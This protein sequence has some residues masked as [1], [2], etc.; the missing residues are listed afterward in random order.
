MW[1]S[2]AITWIN[3]TF[4]CFRCFFF[5]T[6]RPQSQKWSRKWT[7]PPQHIYTETWATGSGPAQHLVRAD[8]L[9]TIWKMHLSL[10]SLLVFFSTWAVFVSGPPERNS[11]GDT[12]L[13]YLCYLKVS[14]VQTRVELLPLRS[15]RPL[16]SGNYS[17]AVFP[18]DLWYSCPQYPHNTFVEFPKWMKS[19]F[20]QLFWKVKHWSVLS[21][22]GCIILLCKPNCETA[23][24]ENEK[25]NFVLVLQE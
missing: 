23:E 7:L 3:S 4:S 14:C 18:E 1:I 13:C 5:Q 21:L 8:K 11:G 24:G 15:L 12:A 6:R 20:I 22:L 9:F 2:A 16:N 19:R 17:P 25:D 10:H